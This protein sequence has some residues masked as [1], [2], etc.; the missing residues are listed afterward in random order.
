M[1]FLIFIVRAFVGQ[2]ES[3]YG[4]YYAFGMNLAEVRTHV[5]TVIM[6]EVLQVF[7]TNVAGDFK[8]YF[9]QLQVLP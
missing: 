4:T 8:A 1:G 3:Y 2:P 5:D 6:R 7:P 9:E